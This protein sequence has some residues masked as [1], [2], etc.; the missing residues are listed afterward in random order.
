MRQTG[1]SA[2]KLVADPHNFLRRSAV[3][4]R[5]KQRWTT[6]VRDAAVGE[7]DRE[8]WMARGDDEFVEFAQVSFARLTHA[9]FLLTGDR[10]D[11]E[12]LAQAALV[13]TYAAWSRVRRQSAHAYARTALVNLVTD[14]WRRPL[15][16]YATEEIPERSGPR[17]LA[18]DVME[19][20]WLIEMLL[21]LSLQERAVVILR[22]YFD[23]S[24]AETA[25]ELKVSV[26]TVKSTNSRAL[27]KLRVC[28]EPPSSSRAASPALVS[29]SPPT[30]PG[31]AAWA[32]QK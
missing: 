5:K 9:A 26:G 19:R 18:D 28:A 24:E 29:M 7:P 4:G 31:S 15:R 22:H 8:A 14:R 16:E 20:R 23:L 21:S 30:G 3:I 2:G 17:N 11:A 1:G 12:D 32:G 27:S 6:D 10:D 25:A 13:R